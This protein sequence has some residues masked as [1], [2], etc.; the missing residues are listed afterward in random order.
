MLAKRR[1]T[2]TFFM[3]LASETANKVLPLFVLYHV[4]KAIGLEAF[5]AAQF[6]IS[7]FEILIPF[8]ALGFSIFGAIEVGRLTGGEPKAL[9]RFLGSIV[10]WRLMCA[11]ASFA[12]LTYLVRSGGPYEEYRS[13]AFAGAFVLFTSALDFEFVFLAKQKLAALTASIIVIKLLSAALILTRVIR[14]EDAVFYL[15][16][17]LGAN[18]CISLVGFGATV[19]RFGLAIPRFTELTATF[20]R[21]L[22]YGLTSLLLL[23]G[24]RID[25][26][27]AESLR[28]EKS[29]GLYAG[30]LRLAGSLMHVVGAVARAF[31]SEMMAE[32]SVAHL[33]QV[34]R[35]EVFVLAA[36]LIPT[37]AGI[38]FVDET[39]LQ[40]FYGAE[41]GGHG[42]LLS[43][44]CLGTAF[45]AATH[46]FGFQ[47]LALRG[48]ATTLNAVMLLGLIL[49]VAGA[50]LLDGPYALIGIAVGFA[51]GKL[52]TA[53]ILTVLARTLLGALPWREMIRPCIAAA[54]MA[55]CLAIARPDPWYATVALGAVIYGVTLS[56]LCKNEI[57]AA[58][59]LV[60][61]SRL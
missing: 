43:V 48:R 32:K 49:A 37:A 1:L 8:V 28:G 29:A 46:V 45:Y 35:L 39:L 23:S 40:F 60:R 25:M 31:F 30:P 42:H 13:F 24:D 20:R 2:L 14:P 6:S 33:L 26:L 53:S 12:A 54:M 50:S 21:A 3:A 34:V 10:I 58:W 5:G 27:L 52:V 47:V 61:S 38:W 22:P 51:F 55:A 57:L 36:V 19:A 17:Y 9:S 7:L 4:Q 56:L 18:A 41:F 11:T 15:V 59:G 16:T 44:M